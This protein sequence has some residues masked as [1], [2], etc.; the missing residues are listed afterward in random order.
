MEK[1]EIFIQ[2]ARKIHGNRYNYSKTIYI[3]AVEK[4]VIICPTH[5]EFLVSP[6]SHLKGS[7][8]RQCAYDKMRK[9][10]NKELIPTDRQTI[11]IQKARKIHNNRY[12]YSRVDYINSKTKVEIICPNHGLFETIPKNHIKGHGCPRCTKFRGLGQEYFLDEMKR[13]HPSLSFIK[14]IYRNNRTLVTVICPNHG[15]YRTS[16]RC[17]LDGHGCKQCHVD[18]QR[19]GLDKF[20][21]L[22]AAAHGDKYRFPPFDYINNQTIIT[23]I[24][25]IHGAW[26]TTPASILDGHGCPNCYKSGKVWNT[27]DFIEKAVD[28]HG[29]AYDYAETAY[30]DSTEKVEIIC[31]CC[32]R[33]FLQLPGNHLQ[34]AGC[35]YCGSSLIQRCVYDLLSGAGEVRFND[36]KTIRP[37]EIDC[38]LPK[39]K[40]G[41]ECHGLY[42]HSEGLSNRYGQRH[43]KLNHQTK[44]L[45]AREA[46]ITVLQFWEHEIN[47][48][49]T[50]VKS[51]ITFRLGQS[52][53]RHD[54]RKLSVEECSDA[55][56]IQFYN[57]N[58][59][60]GYRS[61]SV[62]L[63]LVSNNTPIMAMSFSRCGSGWEIIR[64]AACRG[65]QVR[66]GAS[67]LLRHF[68]NRVEPNHIITF[69]DLRHS[70]GVVYRKL[71]FSEISTTSPN[72]FY[73]RGDNILSRQKCQK[74]K[75]HKLL[76]DFNPE[77]SESENMFLHG[78][79]RVWDAGNLKFRLDCQ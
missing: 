64:M 14:A 36:R 76:E 56:I 59:L 48:K 65:C 17:L 23:V 79:R 5:G 46:G 19:L 31:D 61:A 75:L 77:K 10:K 12:D 50:L 22:A 30:I 67:R 72:Y 42:W 40:L 6:H 62:H 28:T 2:K 71:G 49:T 11:F 73:Y 51:M 70:T 55:A 1:T 33:K 16:P 3:S 20:L 52:K 32:N 78:Y 8:C 21:E 7:R 29:P 69:A 37:L 60:Q 9:T 41:V 25:S 39:Y 26:N 74:H 57:D 63:T 27:A 58:H 47:N 35:P 34:G 66:G 43:D 13:L 4:I 15:E 45:A 44:A 54:A 53:N 38:Y 18:S 68:I 24:C